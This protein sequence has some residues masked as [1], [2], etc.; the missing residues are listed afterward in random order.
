MVAFE[1]IFGATV[2]FDTDS[3]TRAAKVSPT[4][5]VHLS[6]RSPNLVQPDQ[7]VVGENLENVIVLSDEFYQEIVAHPIPTDL[8]AVKV[9]AAAPALLGLF[10]WFW[11]ATQ[12]A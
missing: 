10:M 1:R 4:V 7:R 9:L 6:A 5:T 8:D 2:F 11:D 12:L 3:L